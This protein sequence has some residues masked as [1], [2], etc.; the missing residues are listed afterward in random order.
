MVDEFGAASQFVAINNRWE[1]PM[2]PAIVTGRYDFPSDHPMEGKLYARIAGSPYAH[3]KI[4]SIDTTAAEKIAGVKAVITYKDNS[5]WAS[6]MR[7]VEQPFAAIAAVDEYTA[8][9]ATDLIKVDW[10]I[11]PFVVDPE[12]AMKTGAPLVGT[13]PNSNISP[14]PSQTTWGDVTK[15]FAE[16]DVVVDETTGWRRSH[17]HNELGRDDILAYWD[18]NGVHIWSQTRRPFAWRAT[19]SRALGIPECDCAINCHG[20]GGSFGSRDIAYMEAPAALLARKAGKP[21]QLTVS[22]KQYTAQIAHQ[23][24][25]KLKMKLGAKKDGTLTALDATWWDDG[26]KI[27]STGT[28]WDADASSWVVPNYKKDEWG[29]ATNKNDAG[30]WRDVSGPPGLYCSDLILEKLAD[31]LGI[32]PLEMRRKNF[33]QNTTA[34][35]PT[36]QAI[37]SA[38]LRTCLEKA[39]DAIGYTAKYHAPGTKTLADGRLH[40]V[41]ICAFND[42]K[43]ALSG[44]RGSTIN[45]CEDG[46]VTFNDGGTRIMSGPVAMTAIIAETLGVNYKDVRCADFGCTQTAPEGGIQ[47]GSTQLR[48]LGAAMMVA[49]QD[50]KAQLFTVAAAQLKVNAADLDAKEG[51]IFVKADPTK[52]ITHKDVMAKQE[53]P[54]IG[55]GIRWESVLRRPF[56]PWKTGDVCVHRT[57]TACAWEVAVDPETGEIEIL[58]F[59]LATDAGRIIERNSIEGQYSVGLN[60]MINQAIYFD[61]I[62]DPATGRMLNYN[63]ERDLFVTFMDMPTEKNRYEIVE[64][65]DANGPYGAHGIGEPVA[66][67]YSGLRNAVN[68]AIGKYIDTGP[69]TPMTILKYLGKA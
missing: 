57:G 52:F 49:A 43:G 37:S 9:R 48:S 7:A 24:S 16:A 38:G 69:M 18:G 17:T 67:M 56:G 45:M 8:E 34:F 3:A 65:I 42:N 53:Q 60:N 5:L 13:W 30:T 23:W 59:I 19:I 55:R 39:A 26:G 33:Y 22:R 36:G 28:C 66:G 51:K 68:N 46:T 41:G 11:L 61:D 12:A 47:A 63:F 27:G 62:Y 54:F 1:D 21:V 2:G 58:D 10:E 20:I 50:V 31:K 14:T 35:Q 40:G 25:E 32:N 29:V 44:A 15:G 6:E 64:T 4:K